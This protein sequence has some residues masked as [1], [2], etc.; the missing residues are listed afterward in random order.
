MT[1]PRRW[2]ALAFVV[3]AVLVLF[4]AYGQVLT[5]GPY[6]INDDYQYLYRTHAGSF[7]PGHN[8]LMGMGRPLMAWGVQMAYGLCG[9]SVA[10]LVW[11]RAVALVAVGAFAFLLFRVLADLRYGRG[12]AL[13]VAAL[14][15][16]TP[17]CGVYAAWAAAMF[18]PWALCCALGGG[19]LLVRRRGWRGDLT[20]AGLIVLACANWQA[21]APLATFPILADAWRRTGEHHEPPA[22]MNVAPW[23]RPWLVAGLAVAAYGVFC[24]LTAR[25]GTVSAAGS[26]RLSLEVKPSAKAHFFVVLLRNGVTS[27]ARFQSDPWQ[28]TV[29]AV[30]TAACLL[31]LPAWRGG[32]WWIN[33]TL[34]R[35]GLAVAMIILGATPLL[36]VRENNEGFRTLTCLSIAVI[37]L[38]ALGARRA[39]A[40]AP[41]A[42]RVLVAGLVTVTSVFAARYH[43]WHG[44]IAPSLH[45]YVGVREEVRG[46]FPDEVPSRVVY[47]VPP[48]ASP[49]S[50]RM[51][52]AGEYG[53]TSSAFWWVTQPFLRLLF[54]D[55][56]PGRT[57][58]ADF[59]VAY[60]EA[61]NPGVPV[62]QSLPS[63][64]SDPGEWR[65][66]PR[67]G[68]VR[69]FRDGWLYSPWFGYFNVRW[70]P[71]IEH[72]LLGGLLFASRDSD[73][74]DL[75]FYH[76]GTG[77]FRTG[78]GEYPRLFLAATGHLVTPS[79]DLP[80]QVRLSDDT[81]HEVLPYPP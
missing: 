37:F 79:N 59:Q 39:L 36:A 50:G 7:D 67:W 9:G 73:G 5:R 40:P 28:W 75:W 8:E 69:A 29:G 78:E 30:T 52:A 61:D 48:Y 51:T 17:A 44:L 43:V 23:W 66:D 24:V 16:L 62:V 55:A 27:W 45:E 13:T 15:A 42:A 25:F 18:A 46:Q 47:L 74:R 38:A 76:E 41:R 11:L 19:W 3:G 53:L 4:A 81:T 14:A 1:L 65:D 80:P 2:S 58:P 12:V 77:Y 32:R 68:R 70:F 33:G 35:T 54:A 60:R 64:L 49:L 21:A 56:R 6:G 72:H 22:S 31:A 20:A 26:G 34:R 10:R 63:V 71:Y 57:V